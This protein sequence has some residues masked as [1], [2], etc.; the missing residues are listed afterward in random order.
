MQRHHLPVGADQRKESHRPSLKMK[1]K[2]W[3]FISGVLAGR[4]KG[5]EITGVW[6]LERSTERG[7]KGA[8]QEKSWWGQMG[9]EHK[10]LVVMLKIHCFIPWAMWKH[11]R[12]LSRE[13]RQGPLHILRTVL[14]MTWRTWIRRSKSGDRVNSEE[15]TE[16]VQ[17]RDDGCLHKCASSENEQKRCKSW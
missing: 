7:W 14:P 6:G 11:W 8:E 16:I 15:A 17:G 3:G 5:Q 10:S 1:G 9:S 13:E 4:P 2:D 12:I